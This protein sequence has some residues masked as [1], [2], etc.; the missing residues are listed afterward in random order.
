M[1]AVTSADSHVASPASPA[2]APPRSTHTPPRPSG[3]VGAG[4]ESQTP[5][6]QGLAGEA[7]QRLEVAHDLVEE[8]VALLLV[9]LVDRLAQ[10]GLDAHL[11][12][13]HDA[14]QRVLGKAAAA[15]AQPRVQ[16]RVTD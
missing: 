3:A 10:L 16:E 12:A 15:V 2:P 1:C 7:A 13:H 14:G 4:L 11:V 6:S 9:D 8:A 5:E